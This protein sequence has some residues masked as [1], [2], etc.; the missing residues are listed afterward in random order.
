MTL[1]MKLTDVNT[2]NIELPKVATPL[3]ISKPKRKKKW[4]LFVVLGIL[5]IVLGGIGFVVFK[6]VQVFQKIGLKIDS[7]SLSLSNKQPELQRDST[8]KYTNFLIIGIDTRP[9]TGKGANTDTIMIASYNYDTNNMVMVSVPRDL[10]VEVPCYAG[11]YFKINAVY[12]CA[13][14][15]QAGFQALEKKLKD[16]TGLEVQYY[17]M[18]DFDGVVKIVDAVGGI[19]INVTR[20]FTDI[21]YPADSSSDAGSHFGFCIDSWGWWKTVSFKTGVQH[22]DGKTA[23]E[24]ARSRHGTYDD[25][26]KGVLDYGRA[27]HQQAVVL[28]L[29]DKVLSTSTLTSPKAIMNIFSSISSN[30]K[31]SPFV[32]DIRFSSTFR[33]KPSSLIV[34]KKV[35]SQKV[36]TD[37]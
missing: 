30:L 2:K 28:A 13:G 6:G 29:K 11:G 14:Q 1:D 10:Y 16:V 33:R 5:I 17:A 19:D 22:M 12:A 37:L 31:I 20:A 4:G 32:K 18:V 34:T 15:D 7:S 27:A 21:C 26:L 23:L 36:M 9:A 24:Y 25:T 35:N 8:G 3:E